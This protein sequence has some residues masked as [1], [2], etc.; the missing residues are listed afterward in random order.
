MKAATLAEIKKELKHKSEDELLSYCLSLSRFKKENKEL[1]TYL[2]FEASDEEAYIQSVKNEIEL[3]FTDINTHNYYWM[4]KTIRKV[5]KETRKFI[6][7]SKKKTTEVEL[8][9]YF[10]YQM[11]SLS[12]SIKENTSLSNLYER[13]II[14]I[15]KTIS[16][17]EE[18]LQYD[19]NLQVDELENKS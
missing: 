18:D 9:L 4:K 11:Q 5:L 19:Y 12:P 15:R 1:L 10:C 2:L 13:L 8:L 17:M 6:R 14:S 16:K 7:Y 3:Q